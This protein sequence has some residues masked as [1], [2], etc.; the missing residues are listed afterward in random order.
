MKISVFVNGMNNIKKLWL[1]N[2]NYYDISMIGSF[3]I[4]PNEELCI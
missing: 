1:L 2:E 4:Y 3:E